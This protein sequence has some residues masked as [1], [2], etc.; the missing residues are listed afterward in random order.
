MLTPSSSRNGSNASF[1]ISLIPIKFS[2]VNQFRIGSSQP[3]TTN[4]AKD[5]RFLAG[6][7]SSTPG[8]PQGVPAPVSTLN[9]APRV[10]SLIRKLQKRLHEHVA[11]VN[12]CRGTSTGNFVTLRIGRGAGKL[13]LT[14]STIPHP[15][16]DGKI[17]YHVW[18]V[19]VDQSVVIRFNA[20]SAEPF[21]DR[22]LKPIS[23]RLKY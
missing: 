15:D 5:N 7:G 8:R 23:S 13:D 11:I 2:T 9:D 1:S 21:Y 16:Q 10:E 20:R 12:D 14:V 6:K 18:D 4:Q 17:I 22:L 19:T 3:K